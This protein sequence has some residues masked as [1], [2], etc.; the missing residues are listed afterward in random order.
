MR[1]GRT[2]KRDGKKT[3]ELDWQKLRSRLSSLAA[4]AQETMQPSPEQSRTL[5]KDRA[6]ALAQAGAAANQSGDALEVL[7]L[8]LG[9]ERYAVELRY[10]HQVVSHPRYTP[11]PGSSPMLLGVMNFHGEILPVFDLRTAL[12]RPGNASGG[13]LPASS[14]SQV[15]VLGERRA[16]LGFLCDRVEEIA[17]LNRGMLQDVPDT[18]TSAGRDLLRGV[19]DSGLGIL[20]G[21]RLLTDRRFV[22]NGST[23]RPEQLE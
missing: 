9:E 11:V 19:A 4:A 1:V 22:E 13:L 6:Q 20:D 3:A 2:K 8:R 15:I 5:L 16:D 10:L 7:V 12:G 23:A 17:R 14:S 18:L 21:A